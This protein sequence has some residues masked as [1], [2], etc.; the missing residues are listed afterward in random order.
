MSGFLLP[1]SH[2]LSLHWWKSVVIVTMT[3]TVVI[4]IVGGTVGAQVVMT[5]DIGGHLDARRPT[6]VVGIILL[7]AHLMVVEDQEGR[8]LIHP[9]PVQKGSTLV[10]LD[11]GYRFRYY[12][13][14]KVKNLGSYCGDVM[15]NLESDIP[16]LFFSHVFIKLVGFSGL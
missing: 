10:A 5:M 2:T 14:E 15:T 7:G 16:L 8:G 1:V 6:E 11:E 4:V 9:M 12:L 3:V 13:S